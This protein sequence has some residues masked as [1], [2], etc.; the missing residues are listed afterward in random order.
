MPGTKIDRTE[1]VRLGESQLLQSLADIRKT[2]SS[3][4][5]ADGKPLSAA[6]TQCI[7]DESVTDDRIHFKTTALGLT[8]IIKMTWFPNWKVRGAKQ[9]FCV[10]PG[11]MCVFPDQSDVDLYYGATWSDVMGYVVT[12]IGWCSFAAALL[13]FRNKER[14]FTRRRERAK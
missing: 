4:F 9:V 5:L 14:I 12:I 6:G 1:L 8:H 11:F 3:A 7:S 10:S 2:N 13:W